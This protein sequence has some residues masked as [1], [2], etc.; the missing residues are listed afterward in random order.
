MVNANEDSIRSDI[1]SKYQ[2]SYY[3]EA[4]KTE[5]GTTANFV[6]WTEKN[7]KKIALGFGCAFA[8]AV[9]PVVAISVLPVPA[10]AIMAAETFGMV[11]S[12]IAMFTGLGFVSAVCA[13][14]GR[15]HKKGLKKLE[16]DIDSGVL[17]EGYS[18]GLLEA[19]GIERA[20]L[21]TALEKM[22]VKAGVASPFKTAADPAR[23][24]A[25]GAPAPAVSAIEVKVPAA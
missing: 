10:A 12:S 21:E 19:H 4:R 11:V 16:A 5:T 1:R 8:V 13:A 3:A 18:K 6:R 24:A 22:M 17:L 23:T 2:M 15:M 9:L 25:E 20:K 14:D 7:W